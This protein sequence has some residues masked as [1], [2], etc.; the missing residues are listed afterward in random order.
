M[1]AAAIPSD[2]VSFNSAVAACAKGGQWAPALKILDDM[3]AKEAIPDLVTF[4]SAIE[5]CAKS[6][7][8]DRALR[9]LGTCRRGRW[10]P[11]S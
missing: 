2:I 11:T 3:Q 8:R 6:G 10:P 1:Q 7:Q 9:V 5:A 4:N